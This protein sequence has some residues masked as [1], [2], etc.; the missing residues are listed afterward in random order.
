MKLLSATIVVLLAIHS[1]KVVESLVL[2]LSHHQVGVIDDQSSSNR[3]VFVAG[4]PPT[5]SEETIRSAL[6]LYGA[7]EDIKIVGQNDNTSRK[8]R[9]RNPYCFVT[10]R[11]ASAAKRA[12]DAPPPSNDGTNVYKEIDYASPINTRRR[13]NQSRAQEAEKRSQIEAFGNRTN[14]IVQV[15]S[16]HLERLVAYLKQLNIN[17]VQNNT[18]CEVLGS[19]RTASRSVSLLL[20]SC[21]NALGMTRRLYTDTLLARAINKLYIVQPGLVEGNL[22]TE[23]GCNDFAKVLC[24]NLETL[25]VPNDCDIVCRMQVFPPKHQSRLVESIDKLVNSQYTKQFT[26]SPRGFTHIISVAE[27]YR[28]KGRHS[29]EHLKEENVNLYMLGVSAASGELDVIDNNNMIGEDSNDENVSRAYYKL[30]EA[31]EMYEGSHGKL[32]K[33]LYGS[34]AL[35]CGSAPG[36]WTKYLIE[37]FGCEKVYSVDPGKLAPSVSHMKETTHMQMK[38]QDALPKLLENEASSGKVKV[39][40][41]DMCLH[42]MEAQVELLLQAKEQ[43]VLTSDAFFVLTLKCIVGHSKNAYDEQVGRVV[44]KLRMGASVRAVETYHLFSN[45]SGERTV[46]GYLN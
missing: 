1:C 4:I 40:V 27:V 22:S 31:I 23:Q 18:V 20:L 16:S 34:I 44:E 39:F 21:G 29:K 15:P 43:G 2:S 37:H 42:N 10:F 19:V 7:V 45:R 25:E 8:R 28:Y 46:I 5:C 11:D 9:K 32:C 41:S 3:R 17:G 38:I 26:T 13:S 30:N 35:D 14:L 24:I 6:S 33:S 36:G 12:V